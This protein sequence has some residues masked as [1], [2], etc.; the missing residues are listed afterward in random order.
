MEGSAVIVPR[1]ENEEPMPKKAKTNIQENA[2]DDWENVEK[3]G[4]GNLEVST[5]M[6]EGEKI[7]GASLAE[8]DGEKV[9]K[10]KEDM[11]KSAAGYELV[12]GGKEAENRLG[13]DW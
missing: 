9:E 6:S 8:S 1:G 7:E 2:R 4:D 12:D 3:P 11:V 5:E 13:K 10:P